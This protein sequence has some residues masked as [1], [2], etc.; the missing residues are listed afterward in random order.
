MN[1]I[2]FDDNNIKAIPIKLQMGSQF[3]VIGG[4]YYD[5]VIGKR[6]VFD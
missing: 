1:T 3:N 6:I 2:F 5:T 4:N